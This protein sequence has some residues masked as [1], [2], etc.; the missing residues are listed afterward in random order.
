MFKIDEQWS[1]EPMREWSGHVIKWRK[2]WRR[3]WWVKNEQ[4]EKR[5]RNRRSRIN[6]G[7]EEKAS[8]WLRSDWEVVR[9]W[10]RRSRNDERE[11]NKR[12]KR[13]RKAKDWRRWGRTTKTRTQRVSSF[14]WRIREDWPTPWGGAWICNSERWIGGRGRVQRLSPLEQIIFGEFRGC[15]NSVVAGEEE[16]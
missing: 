7:G 4:G 1:D 12:G 5:P 15:L 11:V 10:R 8:K 13:S 2:K 6:K 3:K 16:M 9:R 14:L